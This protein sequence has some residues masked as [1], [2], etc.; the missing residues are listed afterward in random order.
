VENGSKRGRSAAVATRPKVHFTSRNIWRRL[1][2]CESVAW[3]YGWRGDQIAT[4]ANDVREAFTYEDAMTI[5]AGEFDI[6]EG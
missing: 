2:A 4:F 3:A 5:I 1:E 6:I